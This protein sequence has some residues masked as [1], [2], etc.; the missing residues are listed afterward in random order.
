LSKEIGAA[1]YRG[2][3]RGGEEYGSIKGLREGIR[4]F[5]N[6]VQHLGKQKDNPLNLYS[7]FNKPSLSI[8][9]KFIPAKY[10]L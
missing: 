8:A 2:Q 7:R 9:L 4:Q 5:N 3:N 6:G 1:T 10:S